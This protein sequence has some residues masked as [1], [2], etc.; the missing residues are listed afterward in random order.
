MPGEPS[1]YAI[2]KL[3]YS[4]KLGESMLHLCSQW[5]SLGYFN[6]TLGI[7]LHITLNA[8]LLLLDLLFYF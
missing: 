8:L 7:R 2:Q 1:F 3:S 4:E 5:A 6:L